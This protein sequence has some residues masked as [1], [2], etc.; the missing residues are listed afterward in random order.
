MKVM[1]R[2]YF[3]LLPGKM[4]EAMELLKR[5]RD[6]W[7]RLGEEPD[8]KVYR[9]FAREGDCMHT[10]V[11]HV[12]LNSLAALEAAG[13]KAHASPEMQEI[14]AKW[15]EITETHVTEL[16]MPVEHP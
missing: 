7:K 15:A 4:A 16:Y 9:P 10:I 14:F 1:M 3:K 11:F 12:E 6:G 2:E 8:V 13:E 5:E